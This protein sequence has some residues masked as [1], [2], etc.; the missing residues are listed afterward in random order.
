MILLWKPCKRNTKRERHQ[1]GKVKFKFDWQIVAIASACKAE[2]IYSDDEDIAS[3][4][5][6]VDIPVYKTDALPLP[7]S[8]RQEQIPFEK[9]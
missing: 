3:Y 6:R 7:Q 5:Q 9:P 8:D 1:V 4:A 2:A